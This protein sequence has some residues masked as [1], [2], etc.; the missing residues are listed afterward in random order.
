[1][2][3]MEILNVGKVYVLNGNFSVGTL[4]VLNG[5]SNVGKWYVLNVEPKSKSKVEKNM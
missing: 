2:C 1:M 4:Y 3:W 5:N